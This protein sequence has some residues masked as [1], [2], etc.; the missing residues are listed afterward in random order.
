MF[1]KVARIPEPGFRTILPPANGPTVLLLFLQESRSRQKILEPPAWPYPDCP[2]RPR[3]FRVRER[4]RGVPKRAQFW[5]EGQ[6]AAAVRQ[7]LIRWCRS[8]Q[9]PLV[10]RTTAR[11]PAARRERRLLGA[12]N[13]PATTNRCT[14]P[15]G[16]W[17]F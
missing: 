11:N 2:P 6:K 16:T 3:W 8:S 12:E 7:D 9:L 13:G 4:K 5:A 1:P 17:S 15:A 14:L 10:A